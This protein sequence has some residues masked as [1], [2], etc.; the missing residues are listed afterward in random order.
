MEK[1]DSESGPMDYF[2]DSLLRTDTTATAAPDTRDALSANTAEQAPTEIARIF[3][4]GIRTGTM[5]SED[6]RYVGQV[7]ARQTG[8]TQADAEQRVTDTF[9][10]MQAT[11]REAETAAREAADTARKGTAY[12]SLWLFVS[13]LCGAFVASFAAIYGGL[14][15]DFSPPA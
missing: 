3:M 12:A 2:V 6:L 11:L 8:L 1:S 14:Q 10:R 5:P 15:R 13:L 7:V 4:N 9:A